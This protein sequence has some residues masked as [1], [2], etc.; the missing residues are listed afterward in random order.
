MC[1]YMKTPVVHVWVMLGM[2]DFKKSKLENGVESEE[3]GSWKCVDLL[4]S[5]YKQHLL[6]F[7]EQEGMKTADRILA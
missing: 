3:E 7:L 4:L 6:S 2:Q 5:L 1:V